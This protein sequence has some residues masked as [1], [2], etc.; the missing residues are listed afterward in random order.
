MT[1]RFLLSALSYGHLQSRVEGA[2]RYL[3]VLG[4]DFTVSSLSQSGEY[5]NARF[6][7]TCSRDKMRNV[8]AIMSSFA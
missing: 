3:T 1:R 8:R 7:V 4:V 6:S 5:W 2:S